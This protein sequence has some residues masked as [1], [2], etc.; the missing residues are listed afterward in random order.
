MKTQRIRVA[1]FSGHLA[2]LVLGLMAASALMAGPYVVQGPFVIPAPG[3]G[4]PGPR[5]VE[6]KEYADNPNKDDAGAAAVGQTLLWDGAGGIA[7]GLLTGPP[8]VDSMANVGDALFQ[9]LID[10]TSALIFGSEGRGE[11]FLETIGGAPGIWAV[12]AQIDQ[13]GVRDLS[14]LE[15]WGPENAVDTTHW[16]LRGD[17][18]PGPGGPPCSV[19]DSSGCVYTTLDIGAAIGVTAFGLVDLDALMVNGA[20]IIFS[21][22]PIPNFGID[23]GE[24][25]VWNGPGTAATFL[26]HGGHLWDTAHDVKGHF[27]VANENVQDIEAISFIPEPA[28]FGLIGLA[29]VAAAGRRF[30]KK[31]V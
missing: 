23:G 3:S 28:S 16:S 21:V 26:N 13:H 19:F 2:L 8:D 14:G 31:R 7:N 10:N 15:V 18:A 4:I 11:I 30:L 12:P 27:G 22:R 29:L 24:I 9:S 17:P 5:N 25:W 6:G 20:R 1:S